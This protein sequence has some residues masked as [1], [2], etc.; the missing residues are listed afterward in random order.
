MDKSRNNV[1]KRR[2]SLIKALA[3]G[4]AV[5][6]AGSLPRQWSKPVVDSVMLPAHAQ[7]S[8]GASF[9][10]SSMSMETK[11]PVQG[12]TRWASVLDTLVSPARAGGEQPPQN[13]FLVEIA[14]TIGQ[15][16]EYQFTLKATEV[17]VCPDPVV[18]GETSSIHT[19]TGSDGVAQSAPGTSCDG[20]N[21]P[22]NLTVDFQGN[23]LLASGDIDGL[24]FNFPVF[25][26]GNVPT[27]SPC[28]DCPNG[29]E[30]F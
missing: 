26:G 3:S 24:P 2:R 10:G 13:S 7:T 15:N 27:P 9:Y 30:S 4:G 19:G 21:V 6:A 20:G 1:G 16:G 12:G 11:A 5:V 22:A 8:A 17:F 18:T 14:V 25:P 28:R 29:E 23:S